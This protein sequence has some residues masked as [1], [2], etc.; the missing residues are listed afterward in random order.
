MV[1]WH[2]GHRAV[3]THNAISRKEGILRKSV[4]VHACVRA[5]VWHNENDN[6]NWRAAADGDDD[7]V[8]ED[9]DNSN[10]REYVRPTIW[11]QF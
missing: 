7:D 3:P 5:C 4:C 9:D 10:S 6:D 11:L 1:C 8:Q 2:N